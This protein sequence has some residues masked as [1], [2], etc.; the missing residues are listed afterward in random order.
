MKITKRQLRRIIKEEYRLVLNE[1]NVTIT[2]G[3]SDYSERDGMTEYGFDVELE[4]SKEQVTFEMGGF[5][6]DDKSSLEDVALSL[7]RQLDLDDEDPS[8]IANLT[9]QLQNVL[10]V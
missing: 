6:A 3:Y 9:D 7:T 4:D 1:Q 5:P 2:T 8:L 10:N